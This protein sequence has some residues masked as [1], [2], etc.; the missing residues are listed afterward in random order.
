MVI[1][2]SIVRADVVLTGGVMRGASIL[3][4]PHTQCCMSCAVY[5]K[6]EGMTLYTRSGTHADIR[7]TQ[8]EGV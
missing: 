3:G 8:Q 2:L 7:I 5:R 4:R 6:K 1:G